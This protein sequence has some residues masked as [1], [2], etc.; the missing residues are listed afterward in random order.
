MPSRL[1]HYDN[2]AYTYNEAGELTSKTVGGQTVTYDYDVFGNLR[3]VA[4]PAGP[5]IDYVIDGAQRRVGKKVNGV[6]AKGWLYQDS[7]NPIAEL[8]AMGSV[9]ARFVYGT[10]AN[11]PD[12]MVKGGVIYR[13]IADHRGSLRLI[14][15]ASTGAIAQEMRYD[16]LGRI[17]LDTNPG[18]Q[19]FG[20]AGGLYDY[21]TGFVRF[22][23]RDYDPRWDGGRQ[24]IR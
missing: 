24:S 18:F 16:E 22:G 13:I 7:L 19:P 6:L 1:K 3:Q 20:F 23:A 9:V 11:V 8:D 2:A 21:Q 17:K 14:V 5:V 10:R 12:Y 4:L 15:N